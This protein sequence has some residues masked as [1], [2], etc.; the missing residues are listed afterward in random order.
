MTI[1]L[2][3]EYRCHL[4]DDGTRRALET[5]AFDGKC[6]SY[7]EGYRYVPPGE[8]WTRADG[9][10]FRGE[11]V[12]PVEEHAGLAKAQR[13]Y[14]LDEALRWGS[15]NIPREGGFTASRNY[16]AGSFLALHGQLYETV[17]AIPKG[18]G[19]NSSNVARTTLEHYF[20]VITEE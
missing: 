18:A 3:S 20:D 4:T 9:A 10:V 17:R 14:E 5:K 16:P 19:L 2:D 11:M 7:I 15:L 8:A 12:S 6:A 13:Q 1:Y